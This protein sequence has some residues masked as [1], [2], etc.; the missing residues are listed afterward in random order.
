MVCSY[1]SEYVVYLLLKDNLLHVCN[2]CYS[3]APEF[4][5]MWYIYY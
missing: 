1:I 2:K 3:V 5:N 4:Q